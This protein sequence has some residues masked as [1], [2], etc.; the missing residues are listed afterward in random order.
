MSADTKSM[1]P[2]FQGSGKRICA[3]WGSGSLLDES[4][5]AEDMNTRVLPALAACR[6]EGWLEPASIDGMPPAPHPGRLHYLCY[7]ATRFDEQREEGTTGGFHGAIVISH[8]FTEFAE[9]YNELVFYFL[10]AGY[11][12]CVLEHRGHG[13]SA[14][15]VDSP[16]LVWIDDWRRYVADLAVF[17]QN[18]GQEYAGDQPLNLFCHSMGGGIG[19][20]LLERYPTLFDKAVL[21]APMIAPRT[22]MPMWLTRALVDLMCAL[23]LG[24]RRVFG[25]KPFTGELDLSQYELSSEAR[26]RWYHQLRCAETDYQTYCATFDWVR[27]AMRLNRAVLDPKACAEVETPILLFQAGHDVWVRNRPQN[28]FIRRVQDGGCYARLVRIEESQHEVFSMPNAVYGPYLKQILD[29]Y[30]DPAVGA[31]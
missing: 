27:Q 24:R 25:Q 14:R 8:G 6:E 3:Y 20:A 26:E 17:A 5:Y 10:M 16:S 28:E 1:T 29:F 22:G 19:A 7:D 13:H 21:S 30:A 4:R 2:E 12:V 23:G 15:D 18:V 11:S 9:K 31:L